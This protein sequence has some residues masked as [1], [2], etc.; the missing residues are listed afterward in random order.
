M[1]PFDYL[2]LSHLFY[3][4]KITATGFKIKYLYQFHGHKKANRNA[5]GRTHYA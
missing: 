3:L 1:K 2:K 4:A 5:Q